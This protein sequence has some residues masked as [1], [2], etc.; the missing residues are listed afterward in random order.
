V[1]LDAA[2]VS[3]P[4]TARRVVH[5][6]D[7]PQPVV[8][9]QLTPASDIRAGADAVAD[10]ADKADKGIRTRGRRGGNLSRKRARDRENRAQNDG[11]DD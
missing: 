5:E 10:T 4:G 3:R 1:S 8:H 9:V 6:H 7:A 11:G 2:C